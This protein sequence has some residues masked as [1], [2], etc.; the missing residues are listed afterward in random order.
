MEPLR[1]TDPTAIGGRYRLLARLGSG[2]M[3]IVY[4]GRSPGGRLVAV[5]CVHW[6]LA[7]DLIVQ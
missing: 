5:K 2:G 1:P 4:L 3:G 7:T 6:D